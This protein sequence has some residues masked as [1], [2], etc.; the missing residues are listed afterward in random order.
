MPTNRIVTGAGVEV[1][2]D[3]DGFLPP[4]AGGWYT[5]TVFGSV[6][7]RVSDA[8]NTPNV[9]NGGH[10][11]WITDEYSTM[12]PFNT[13]NSF[14]ILIHESYFGLYDSKGT[15]LKA[16]PLE[17][18]SSSEPR[19]SRK[20]NRTL[21]YRSGNQL[22]ACDVL[23]GSLT[24]V[25]TF[26][27]YLFIEGLG[28]S[29]ISLDGDH[30]AFCGTRASDGVREVFLYR[31]ST[32]TKGRALPVSGYPL[33]AIYVTPQNHVLLSW[34]TSGTTRYTGQELFDGD[35][36]FLSQ[37]TRADGHKHLTVDSNGDEVLV[38]CNSNDPKPVCDNGIVKV[39]LADGKQ[40]CLLSLDWSLA[41]H[42]SAPDN[43]GF[44]YVETYDPANPEPN[45]SG[46][47]SYTNEILQVAL[48]GSQ[49][50]R[51]AHHR[52]RRVDSYNW[53]P[54]VSC[55]RDG[56]RVVFNSN[57]N[58]QAINGEPLEY[59][60]VYTIVTGQAPPAPVPSPVPVKWKRYEQSD[61]SIRYTGKWFPNSGSFNSGGS[62]VLGMDQECS[63]TLTFTGTGVRWVG[64]RDQ[65]SGMARVSLDGAAPSTVD[66]YSARELSQAVV[67]SA[68][69]LDD[70]LHTLVITVAGEKN[71]NSGGN[72]VWIDA[73]DVGT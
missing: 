36:G 13:D 51:L 62:A 34:V 67:W 14:L 49:V 35:M 28:E 55:S 32:G 69:G 1:P 6:V 9:A 33:D 16:L 43:A 59:A 5:D 45:S 54:R 57:F 38:W 46:W 37:I 21:Y 63:A 53:Q 18:N 8:M 52:S 47:R 71:P 70:T 40:T 17:V 61:Q 7:R 44:V 60:D 29:D 42:I 66:T 24:V 68:A 23:N 20:D 64:H 3:Y 26:P 31:I 12:S 19:W 2:V 56:S 65:W 15:Y 73:F 58:L 10:L 50:T 72:W 41:V 30:L 4:G 48:D 11:T 25:R 27:E 39:R 22:K